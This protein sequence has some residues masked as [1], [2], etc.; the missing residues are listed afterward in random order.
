MKRNLLLL[1]SNI[2]FLKSWRGLKF[3]CGTKVHWSRISRNVLHTTVHTGYD[4]PLF[5]LLQYIP[6]LLKVCE[7][8]CNFATHECINIAKNSPDVSGTSLRILY[9]AS[10]SPPPPP[11]PC[12]FGPTLLV[13]KKIK[14]SLY[15]DLVYMQPNS[16]FVQFTWLLYR[17]MYVI[18]DIIWMCTRVGWKC[19]RLTMMQWSNLTNVVYISTL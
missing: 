14:H 5:Q 19:H 11:P 15:S 10:P 1:L 3:T 6:T 4:R 2:W 8:I 9:R 16:I 7:N 18:G 17:N 13:K 12:E